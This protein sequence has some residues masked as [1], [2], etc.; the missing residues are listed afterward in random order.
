MSNEIIN[1]KNLKT[2]FEMFVK[3]KLYYIKKTKIKNNTGKFD[4]ILEELLVPTVEEFNNL[5][6]ECHTN[7]CHGNYKE[8]K[9][10]FN[11]S[12]IGYIGIDNIIKDYVN[13]CPACIQ[14]TRTIHREDL[15]KSLHADGPDNIYEFDITYLNADMAESF[16]IKY[17]LGILDY[18]VWK[19]MIYGLK[20]K[21]ADKILT[22][23]IEF[24]L[25]LN[26]PKK[27]ISDNGP[28]FKNS[29]INLFCKKIILVSYMGYLISPIHRVQ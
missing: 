8:L 2:Q 18:F 22:H 19:A 10:K 12:K 13:N 21:N 9:K 7:T 15:I 17:I 16:G 5:L 24:C 4:I 20:N 14:I 6:Y 1:I 28:E 23:I 26:F 27:F 29:K 11:K 3:N 25:H